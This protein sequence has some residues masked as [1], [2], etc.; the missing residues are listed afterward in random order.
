[1]GQPTDPLSW[2]NQ[3]FELMEINLFEIVFIRIKLPWSHTKRTN[4][5][6]QKGGG[7]CKNI[8]KC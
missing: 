7:L 3:N 4:M 5:P 1:M 2:E 8:K 6:L